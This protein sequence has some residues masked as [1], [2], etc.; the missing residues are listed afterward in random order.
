VWRLAWELRRSTEAAA[1]A[2]AAFEEPDYEL[3][4]RRSVAQNAVRA[5]SA[6]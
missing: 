3:T 6:P 5:T 4:V 1:T 2:V